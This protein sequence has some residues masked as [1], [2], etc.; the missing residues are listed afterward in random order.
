MV[1]SSNKKSQPLEA[2]NI[3]ITAQQAIDYISS[4]PHILLDHPHLLAE[5]ML[6]FTSSPAS[7][8]ER[9]VKKLREINK[10][11]ESQVIS[12]QAAERLKRD[13]YDKGLKFITAIIGSKSFEMFM[14]R[15][16]H[17]CLKAK[18]KNFRLCLYPNAAQKLIDQT[19]QYR[20]NFKILSEEMA[21]LC[22]HKIVMKE[23]IIL[24]PQ[25]EVFM[26]DI[27]GNYTPEMSA[28]L[29][30]LRGRCDYGFLAFADPHS[31]KY[32]PTADTTLLQTLQTVLPT[33]LDSFVKH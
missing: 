28:A 13:E 24:G 30:P 25:R 32:V 21:N 7:L 3:K 12:T 6:P 16:E 4:H 17:Q 14:L 22:K 23:N 2:T 26:Q 1:L 20:P 10:E 27:F 18:L 11:L 8:V 5:I 19:K 33:L 9:Q 15:L 31:K 29:I